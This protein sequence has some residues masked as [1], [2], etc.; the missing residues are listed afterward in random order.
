MS[1]RHLF[2]DIETSGQTAD[3]LAKIKPEFQAN[4]TLKD[5][6]KIKADL[7]A[8]EQE[9]LDRAALDASTGKVLVIG[10][11]DAERFEC[12][13]GPEDVILTR[14]WPWL[15]MELGAGNTVS[16][17]C[18]FYFDLPFLIR[19]S[20][21]HGVRIPKT[22]RPTRYWN[23]LLVDIAELW[24]CGNRDQ[25]ISLDMLAKTLGVGQKNGQG[26]D[27]ARLWT[28]DKAKALEYLHNDLILAQKCYNRMIFPEQP[29]P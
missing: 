25:K 27:F 10:V 19:R 14:F 5:P 12:F 8:K 2:I 7:A 29:N 6:E 1:T 26:A 24:Q 3:Q 16:G 17:F 13:E 21:V 20:Y 22:I 11:L 18:I 15:D 9:W 23:Q 4:K 28:E